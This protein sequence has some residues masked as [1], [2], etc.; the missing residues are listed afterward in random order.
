VAGRAYWR[1]TTVLVALLLFYPILPNKTVL[2]APLRL[3]AMLVGSKLLEARIAV[4]PMLVGLALINLLEAHGALY[5]YTV[6][7]RMIAVSAA[8]QVIRF[9]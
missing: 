1:V 9:W 6:N 2:L 7:L 4:V 5:F 3:V 8:F